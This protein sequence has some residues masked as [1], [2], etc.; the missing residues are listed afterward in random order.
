[1][2]ITPVPGDLLASMATACIWYTDTH[3][4]KHSYTYKNQKPKKPKKPYNN[5]KKPQQKN[6]KFKKSKVCFIKRKS[7]REI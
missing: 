1:L 4:G 6:F 3:S 5:N 7:L 2:S